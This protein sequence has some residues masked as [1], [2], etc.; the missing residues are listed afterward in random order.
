MII[1]LTGSNSFGLKAQLDRHVAEFVKEHSD[2]GLERLDGEDAEF[3]RIRESLESLPFL[4]SKKTVVLRSP[5]GNKEFVEKAEILLA[6]IPETIDVIIVEPKLD[7]RSSYYKYLKKET[8][9]KEFNELDEFSLAKWL[10]EQAKEAGGSLSQ[11]DAK[12]LVERVGANQQLLSNELAKLL[13]YDSKVT[14]AT[15][16]LLTEPTPQ[17]TIFELLDAAFAGKTKQALGLYREQRA[18]KAEP[19][20]II[21]MLAWQLHV[22]AVIKTAGK[23]DANQIASEAKINPFVVRK[24]L[25]IADELTL[26][27]LKTLITDVLALDVRMKSETIDADDAMM[28]LLISISQK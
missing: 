21:A 25:V 1:T 27:E 7:K 26:A 15:I 24:S 12:Y 8:D 6:N 17:S 10:G 18:L 16:E 23:R 13:D 22:L 14:H 2:L 3:G 4:A 19:I 5:S 28:Q 11:S 9:L 20:Q